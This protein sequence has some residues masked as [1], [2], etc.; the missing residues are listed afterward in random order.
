M[1]AGQALA[2]PLDRL[3]AVED[4]TP[5]MVRLVFPGERYGLND[6]LANDSEQ[7]LVEFYDATCAGEKEFGPLGQFVARYDL[8][9]FRCHPRGVGIKLHGGE[10][11]WFMSA[12]ATDSVLDWLRAA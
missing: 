1:F 3:L 8:K 4:G 6:C 9:T 7:T 10:P 5:W 11:V 12:W 2:Q